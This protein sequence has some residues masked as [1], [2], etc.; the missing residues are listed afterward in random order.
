MTSGEVI[1]ADLGSEQLSTTILVTV[2]EPG[3]LL[4]LGSGAL[5]LAGL[6]RRRVSR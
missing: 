1:G 5:L 6:A 2:P 3:Q 4:L